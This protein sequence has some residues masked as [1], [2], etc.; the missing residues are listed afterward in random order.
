MTR[1]RAAEIII[2]DSHLDVPA[3]DI[4]RIMGGNVAEILNL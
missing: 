2:I 4:Q 3:Q 1:D